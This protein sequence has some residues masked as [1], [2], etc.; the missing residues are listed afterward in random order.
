MLIVNV[1]VLPSIST[2][3]KLKAQMKV[4]EGTCPKL[5]GWLHDQFLDGDISGTSKREWTGH[6]MFDKM[7]LKEDVAWNS[8][9]HELTGLVDGGKDSSI[10]S[11]LKA[12][13]EGNESISGVKEYD[14]AKSVQQYR[15]RSTEGKTINGEFFYNNGSL[16]A[17]EMLSQLLQ[18]ITSFELVG[19]KIFMVLADAGGNKVCWLGNSRSQCTLEACRPGY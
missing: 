7:K 14:V 18:V 10:A 1:Q 6:L 13:L 19:C 2:L 11:E 17:D 5:Y 16:T 9:T 12:L 15:F 8:S 4:N 3:K